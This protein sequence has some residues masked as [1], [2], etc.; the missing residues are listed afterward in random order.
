MNRE[1]F[2]GY[3]YSLPE[4]LLRSLTGLGGGAVREVSDVLLPSR[5]RRSRLYESLVG[6]TRRLDRSKEL[7]RRMAGPC[8]PIF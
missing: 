6:S 8:R 7:T 4:R 3:L 5:V 1:Q 2:K